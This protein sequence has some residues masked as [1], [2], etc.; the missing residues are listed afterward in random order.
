[1]MRRVGVLARMFAAAMLAAVLATSPTPSIGPE[2][3]LDPFF[4]RYPAA[5]SIGGTRDAIVVAGTTIT[6]NDSQAFY[7]IVDNAPRDRVFLTGRSRVAQ[8]V[9]CCAE[10]LVGWR[11][12]SG[13]QM[14]F[15]LR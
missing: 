1:G 6:G 14:L 5:L 10:T 11:D 3:V 4:R 2:V 7:Q 9:T 12:P 13:T 8:V 15:P